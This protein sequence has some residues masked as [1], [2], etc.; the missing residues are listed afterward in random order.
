MVEVCAAVNVVFADVQD[1]V[2]S[3][4]AFLFALLV[5][6]QV[7]VVVM[8]LPLVVDQAGPLCKTRVIL[9]GVVRPGKDF[10][11]NGTWFEEHYVGH[12][13]PVDIDE[14]VRTPHDLGLLM[15]R[16]LFEVHNTGSV[17]IIA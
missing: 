7:C 4:C 10:N 5:D 6:E 3:I 11:Y 9:R 14:D 12:G 17:F 15:E 8:L 13:S 2:E 1:F 16:F